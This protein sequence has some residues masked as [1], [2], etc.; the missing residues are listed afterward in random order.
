[1]SYLRYIDIQRGERRGTSSLAL[2]GLSSN[3]TDHATKMSSEMGTGL[4]A[5]VRS[6]ARSSGGCEEKKLERCWVDHNSYL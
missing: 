4:S 6:A 2:G 1:M 3:C 5:V